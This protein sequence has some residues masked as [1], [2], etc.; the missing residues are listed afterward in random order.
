MSRE[1]DVRQFDLF[2]GFYDLMMPRADPEVLN[3]GLGMARREITRGLD[4]GGG[5]GRAA[6][7]VTDVEWTVVDASAEMLGHATDR[8]LSGVRGDAARL[9]VADDAVDAVMIVDALHHMGAQARVLAEAARV[10]AP[11]GVLVIRDFDPGTIL[12]RALVV[13]EHL[14]GFDS[15]FFRPEE[16]VDRLTDAGF[17]TT[18]PDR[19][20]GYTVVGIAPE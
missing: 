9:P 11:G 6:Q 2:A 1:S 4:I 15:A 13:G 8:G 5:T 20:F 7:S 3:Q 14:I 17:R 16:L 12:G 18:V 10:I 19:G